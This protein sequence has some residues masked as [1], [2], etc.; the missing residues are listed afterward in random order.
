[1]GIERCVAWLCGVQHL[2]ETSP[3]PRLINRLYP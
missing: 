3:F 1:M 2:R